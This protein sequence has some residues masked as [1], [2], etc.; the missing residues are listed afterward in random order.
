MLLHDYFLKKSN[1]QT[2]K[3]KNKGRIKKIGDKNRW[4]FI[5]ANPFYIAITIFFFLIEL[6]KTP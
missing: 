1:K 5:R 2:N 6:A 3:Q 4:L